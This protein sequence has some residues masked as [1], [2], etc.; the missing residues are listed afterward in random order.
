MRAHY[1]IVAVV[2]F[3]IGIGVTLLFSAAPIAGADAHSTR[4]VSVDVSP[5]HQSNKSLPAQDFHDMTFVFPL[6]ADGY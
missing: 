2:S 1:V 3:L 5:L 4:P 6:T